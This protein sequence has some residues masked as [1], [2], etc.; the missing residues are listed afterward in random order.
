MDQLTAYLAETGNA[1]SLGLLAGSLSCGCLISLKITGRPFWW[2]G[3]LVAF[4]HI[5]ALSNL[6][7]IVSRHLLRC[8]AVEPP[9]G[10]E[11]ARC[12]LQARCSRTRFRSVFPLSYEGSYGRHLPIYYRTTY[13]VRSSLVIFVSAEYG[14]GQRVRNP[15][16]LGVVFLLRRLAAMS[17]YWGILAEQLHQQPDSLGD[18][19]L[20]V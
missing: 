12:E 1:G 10:F 13:Q 18:H 17:T 20:A 8:Q 7:N 2:G 3:W 15:P 6:P 19:G 5:C 11:P 14:G 4:L 16:L 9:A